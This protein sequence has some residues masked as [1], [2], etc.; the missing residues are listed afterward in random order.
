V[1]A[2]VLRIEIGHAI[3]TKDRDGAK[4]IPMADDAF[5]SSM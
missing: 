3:D 2:G 5:R 1:P 4:V